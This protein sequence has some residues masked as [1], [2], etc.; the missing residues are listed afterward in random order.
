MCDD[1]TFLMS[2]FFYDVRPAWLQ[3]VMQQV[4]NF[5]SILAYNKNTLFQLNIYLNTMKTII[6]LLIAA[7]LFTSCGKPKEE[8]YPTKCF[9]VL[10]IQL[11]KVIK[12]GTDKLYNPDY[13]LWMNLNDPQQ[14]LD[15]IQRVYYIKVRYDNGLEQTLIEKYITY[16]WEGAREF[17]GNYGQY[18]SK[19]EWDTVNVIGK[20]QPVEQYKISHGTSKW[21]RTAK[22]GDKICL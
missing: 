3:I 14:L 18:V 19:Y 20:F 4:Q 21:G 13:T 12:Q 2:G 5:L 10:E 8:L 1:L 22:T 6:T 7:F 17:M 15:T 11:S 9:T 16:S